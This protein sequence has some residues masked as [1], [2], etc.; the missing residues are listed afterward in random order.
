MQNPGVHGV[1]GQLRDFA[2]ARAAVGFFEI[3][4]VAYG[5]HHVLAQSGIVCEVFCDSLRRFEHILCGGRVLCLAADG[6][7]DFPDLLFVKG[8][9][10]R[11]ITCRDAFGE[12]FR[13]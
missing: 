7:V 4:A 2:S 8:F 6:A 10:D 11:D 1:F 12:K 9:A 3:A 13:V 5:V